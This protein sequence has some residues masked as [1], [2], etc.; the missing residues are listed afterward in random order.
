MAKALEFA[1]SAQDNLKAGRHSACG[2]AAVHAGI[3]AA[4]AVT[5]H[6]GRVISSAQNHLEVIAL[7]RVTAPQGL[8]ATAERQLVGLLSAKNDIEYSGEVVSVARATVM[9][10]Q[11]N[12]FVAWGRSVI[13]PGR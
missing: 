11:A 1:E 7:L 4:D 3:S 2:L 5:A 6:F 9:S 8:P 12:R 13:G 10:D